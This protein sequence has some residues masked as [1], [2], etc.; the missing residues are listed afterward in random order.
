MCIS[1]L[2]VDWCS[3][4]ICLIP[5]TRLQLAV[6][7]MLKSVSSTTGRVEVQMEIAR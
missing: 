5:I 3:I 1:G 2:I 7:I 6:L 4:T